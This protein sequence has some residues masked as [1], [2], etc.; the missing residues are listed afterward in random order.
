MESFVESGVRSSAA[1]AA[2]KQGFT[3][4]TLQ[5]DVD[6]V[7]ICVTLL[8]QTIQASSPTFEYLFVFKERQC[9]QTLSSHLFPGI[10]LRQ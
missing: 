10:N 5:E 2:S 4:I 1:A 7:V 9:P 8:K 3:M 6:E